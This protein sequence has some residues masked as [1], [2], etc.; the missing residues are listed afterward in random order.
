[1]PEPILVEYLKGA[2]F[3]WALALPGNIAPFW[4]GFSEGWPS[5]LLGPFVSY[6]AKSLK[7][8]DTRAS[9]LKDVR[10]REDGAQGP[11]HKNGKQYLGLRNY[12]IR[13]K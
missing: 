6:K 7:G 1:M 8:F 4:E 13:L 9:D 12:D 3:R 2:L 11:H 10:D 5:S